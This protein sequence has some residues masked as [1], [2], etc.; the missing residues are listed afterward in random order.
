MKKILLIVVMVGS[1]VSCAFAEQHFVNSIVPHYY[2]WDKNENPNDK[3]W[4]GHAA[5]KMAGEYVTGDY[6]RLDDLHVTMWYNSS[7]YRDKKVCGSMYCSRLYDLYMAAKYSQYNGYGKAGSVLRSVPDA[8]IF[9]QKV[10]D[11]VVNNLPPIADSSF[12]VSFGHFYV[13]VGYEEKDTDENS[14]IYL[15]DPIKP[16]PINTEW[17][18]K[19]TVKKFLAGMS[20]RQFLF[21]S[22]N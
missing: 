9:L 15:R 12:E 21:I 6:K 14:V 1:L 20:T 8:E 13:I 18:T 22:R 3:Y 19:T 7:Y 10:K 16:N 17:D 4:C 2:E 5:L 11:G